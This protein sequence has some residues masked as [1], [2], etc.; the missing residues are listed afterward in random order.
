[1]L[2][3]RRARRR[4]AWSRPDWVARRHAARARPHATEINSSDV[5]GVGRS[6]LMTFR[7]RFRPRSSGKQRSHNFVQSSQVHF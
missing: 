1:M 3:E 6:Q 2:S 4:A 7:P 5:N